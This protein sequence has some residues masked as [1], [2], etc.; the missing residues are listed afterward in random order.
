MIDGDDGDGEA[1][2]GKAKA[3]LYLKAAME[4]LRDE[5]RLEEEDEGARTPVSGESAGGRGS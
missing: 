2:V 5:G 3:K 1:V 4:A